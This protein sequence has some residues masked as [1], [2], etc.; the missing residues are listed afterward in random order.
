MAARVLFT[1]RDSGIGADTRD[2]QAA[3]DG[4]RC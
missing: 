3:L 4:Y 2:L 1:P